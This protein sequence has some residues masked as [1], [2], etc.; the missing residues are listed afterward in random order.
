M[1]KPTFTI[2]NVLVFPGIF[3]GAIDG[4]MQAVADAVQKC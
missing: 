1:D 2:N 4:V 3:R